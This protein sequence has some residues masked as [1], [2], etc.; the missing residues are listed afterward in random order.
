MLNDDF[1]LISKIHPPKK[2]AST[3]AET[4]FSE[5]H[6]YYY[7]VRMKTNPSLPK[8]IC[9]PYG[10][11][12]LCED[13]KQEV[14]MDRFKKCKAV[15]EGNGEKDNITYSYYKGMFT[16]PQLLS[17]LYRGYL[18]DYNLAI[19]VYNMQHDCFNIFSQIMNGRGYVINRYNPTSKKVGKYM[20]Y[21]SESKINLNED[22]N[23]LIPYVHRVCDGM[24]WPCI[25]HKNN[26][27]FHLDY[28]DTK[29][30]GEGLCILDGLNKIIDVLKVNDTWLTETP[31][32]NRL[33]FAN[34]FVDYEPIEYGKCWS[35]RSA[36][37]MAEICNTTSLNGVL[38]RPCNEDY[39]TN[40]WFE[41]NETSLIYCCNI[42]NKLTTFNVKKSKPKFYT[43]EGDLGEVN[44]IE[45]RVNERMWLD[46]F[47]IKEFC[48][49]LD[50]NGNDSTED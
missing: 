50:L 33:R 44:P 12:M 26:R 48:R 15:Y 42:N 18:F 46:D 31:L 20:N 40:R 28:L 24:S 38:I 17:L 1:R 5:F 8:Q 49:I 2:A 29:R 9:D 22:G 30:Y 6:K 21:A 43:L 36:Y 14:H 3:N 32:A 39:F 4:F 16:F 35:L 27:G 7:G 19:N 10:F 45:E 11:A 34:Q 25:V 23:I 41:W 37:E 47:D 13:F